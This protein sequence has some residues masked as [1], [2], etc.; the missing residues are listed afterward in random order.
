M[1]RNVSLVQ[2]LP[3]CSVPISNGT[4]IL[5]EAVNAL[6]HLALINWQLHLPIVEHAINANGPVVLL[7]VW[8]NSSTANQ[9]L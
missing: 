5:V 1:R 2:P 9:L 8:K 6:L 7:H 4:I 3:P